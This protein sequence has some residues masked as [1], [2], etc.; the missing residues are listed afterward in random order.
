MSDTPVLPEIKQIIGALL[1]AAREPVSLD[2]LRKTFRDAAKNFEG[3]AQEFAKV[4][5]DDL[6]AAVKAL[7]DDLR[8]LHTGMHV[9][10]VAN[11]YRLQNDLSCGAWIRQMLEKGR[12]NRLSKPALET[13]AIIAY[14]QPCTRS[15]IEAVR[16]VAVD[17][18]MKNLIEMQLVKAVGRSDLPG[19][20]W[21]FATTAKF[22]EYF[23]LNKI[24]DLPGIDEMRR[25][26]K[27]RVEAK[28]A[29][30]EAAAAAA[31]QAAPSEQPELPGTAPVSEADTGSVEPGSDTE[32]PPDD[33][34]E[35]IDA[36]EEDVVI[37]E[38]DEADEDDAEEDDAEEDDEDVD[39]DEEEEYDDD[40]DDEDD[41][42]DEEDEEDE[43]ED[44][45]E[46][47]DR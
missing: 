7:D 30:A 13:L 14:R 43:E 16:G 25:M 24:D 33:E 45:D 38:N 39:D 20:P 42:D 4:A 27:A 23:G 10:E 8:R 28:R 19:R 11:G 37:A 44:E 47:D 26:E 22:L 34:V 2:T 40:D 31:A 32:E 17:T 36:E 12:S 3:P 35:E 46:E 5:D 9:G 21:L 18:L 41:E 15:D 1:F 29:E 6:L